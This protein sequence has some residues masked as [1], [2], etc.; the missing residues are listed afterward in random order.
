M[1]GYGYFKT[2]NL[3]LLPKNGTPYAPNKVFLWASSFLQVSGS[4]VY[5]KLGKNEKKA[6]KLIFQASVV[7]L[8]CKKFDLK[9]LFWCSLGPWWGI[10]ICKVVS[11]CLFVFSRQLEGSKMTST[12]IC[13]F[14]SDSIR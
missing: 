1:F 11:E 13:H 6:Q 7:I 9:A 5:K 10:G 4:I 8:T 2:Q 14:S 3:I 12:K